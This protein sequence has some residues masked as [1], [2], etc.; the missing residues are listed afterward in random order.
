M[1]SPTKIPAIGID[2]KGCQG[3]ICTKGSLAKGSYISLKI[4]ENRNRDTVELLI[5]EKHI[6]GKNISL[7]CLYLG[8]KWICFVYILQNR[9]YILV[10]IQV[11]STLFMK[12]S[13]TGWPNNFQYATLLWK[14]FQ[15]P[16]RSEHSSYCC[17]IQADKFQLRSFCCKKVAETLRR[18]SPLIP[19]S[20]LHQNYLG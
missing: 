9:V 13:R 6:F 14:I 5:Q 18:L 10:K 16:L 7:K 4:L 19:V 20:T 15:G 12:N 3:Q 11:Q 1:H 2:L 8:R 17:V